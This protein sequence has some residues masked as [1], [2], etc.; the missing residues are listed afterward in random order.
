M[1]VLA[2]PA[3]REVHYAGRPAGGE[4]TFREIDGAWWSAPGDL[5]TLEADGTLVFRGR[6]SRV[7]NTGGEK[8]PPEEVEEVLLRHPAIADAIV[9]G[10]PDER[11]GQRITAVVALV[12]GAEL[13][14]EQV[15]DAVGAELA[16]HKR[17]RQVV[18]VPEV[19]RSPAGKADLRWAGRVAGTPD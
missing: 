2:A 10:V 3:P 16:D 12:P 13:T 6:G 19:H 14:A 17:P 1:G 15:R 11:F 5:A 9:V 7:I 4:D 18:F 8:V